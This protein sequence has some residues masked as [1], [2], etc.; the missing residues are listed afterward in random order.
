MTSSKV[1]FI[2]GASRGFGREWATAALER[3]DRVAAIA[4]DSSGLNDLVE[5]FGDAILPIQLD[6][7]DRDAVF[8]AVTKAHERFD[9]LDVIINNA[10]AW[11]VAC[12]EEISE[13]EAR[14][15]METNFFGAL[16]VSQAALPYLRGQGSGHIIQI[17]SLGGLTTFP[18]F[19]MYHA[20]KW[21]LEGFSQSLAD[22]VSGFGI[23]V[24]VVEP[25]V[26]LTD[27]LE[28][29][30]PSSEQN[31]AYDDYRETAAK[32]REASRANASVG[33]PKA[34]AAA[35]LQIVD[36]QE[37][38]LRVFFGTP[39]LEIVK[40]EYAKRLATWDK[41]SHIAE[42]AQGGA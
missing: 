36:A 27:G 42:L 6:V 32:R 2:T 38:P 21:A 14:G 31:R 35:M 29:P 39:P 7:K 34:S 17:S 13:A 3:G 22:E 5:K 33:D 1:W 37:P 9:H 26:F 8:A 10:G 23:S 11:H 15:P 4:R 25:G 40:A 16:W 12:I 28:S 20:S 30:N 41:W 19:S 18:L 24:T